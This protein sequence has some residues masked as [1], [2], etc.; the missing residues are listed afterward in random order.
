MGVSISG[1]AHI[2]LYIKDVERSKK[3]YTE[4][5]GFET[6]CEFV[7][8]EGNKMAFVKSGNLIIELIQHKVWMDRKDGLF[9]HIAMEVENIEETSKKLKN[10]GIE[11]EAD[12][13]FDNLV[14]DN[15]VKY[16]AF[17]G[18]DGEHLEIYQTL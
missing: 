4:V 11:F 9:D 18:P 15:G 10:L 16:Q 17:R 3:F 13:Y 7:S 2:G 6:I 8:L 5:L 12:I 14:F 1:V